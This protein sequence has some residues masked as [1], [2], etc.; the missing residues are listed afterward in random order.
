[1]LPGLAQADSDSAWGLGPIPL[2]NAYPL[3]RLHISAKPLSPEVKPQ[4]TLTLS[5]SLSWSNT[6]NIVKSRYRV[7]TE[8]RTLRLGAAFVPLDRLE[9]SFELPIEYRGG[10]ILDS[11]LDGWHT[12]FGFP[13]GGRNDVEDNQFVVRGVNDD[14]SEFEL[15]KHGT[16]FGTAKVGTKYLILKG[17]ETTPA[18]SAVAQIGL[19]TGADTFGHNG[20]DL[21]AGAAASNRWGRFILYGSAAYYYYSDIEVD[22]L[23]LARHNASASLSA[24]YE[25]TPNLSAI[26]GSTYYSN[27]VKDVQRFPDYALYLDTGL[28]YLTG[29]RTRI[30]ALLRENLSPRLGSTDVTFHLGVAVDFEV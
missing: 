18:L 26:V 11:F 22:G 17:S 7:D 14:E 15:E 10:G 19:P 9:L 20:I 13:R 6:F 23:R 1:M 24:E 5:S 30:D 3:S 29:T 8:H 25:L 16:R 27:M 28:T 2:D 12:F 4:G 21:L